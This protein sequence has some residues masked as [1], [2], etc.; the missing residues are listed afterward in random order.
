MKIYYFE[1]I[2]MC[3]MCWDSTGKH[4]VLGQRLNKQQGLSTKKKAGI[5]VS[6]KQCRNCD[7]IYSSPLPIP[8]DILDHYGILPEGY[9]KPSYFEWTPNYFSSQIQVAKQ[10]LPFKGGMKALDIGAGLGKAILLLNNAGFD[11]YGLEPSV[12][13]MKWQYLKWT[14]VLIG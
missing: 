10:L 1:E 12:P 3:E 5:S 11:S 6:I 8:F 9:W 14:S 13:F 4:K 2:S 7:L